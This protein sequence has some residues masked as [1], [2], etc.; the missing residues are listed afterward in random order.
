MPAMLTNATFDFIEEVDGYSNPADLVLAF[1]RHIEKFG[2]AYF[3]VGDPRPPPSVNDYLWATTWPEEWLE[4]WTSRNYLHVDPIV[5]QLR[6]HNKPLSWSPKQGA[7]DAEGLRILEEAGEFRM[8]AGYAVPVYSRDGLAV[9]VSMGAEH[10]ELSKTDETCLHMSSIYLHAGL[11]RLRGAALL[12]GP[13]LTKRERD[14]LSWVAK[15]KTDWEISQILKI[16]EQ[17]V[18]EYVQNAL[19]K[20]NATTRA[21][22]VA[23]AI[24]AKLIDP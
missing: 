9:V 21:Q 24:A 22:A 23:I 7:L 5:R 17:T 11:E 3:M 20:L 2:I 13:K 15:G 1:R 12:R 16:A 8:S 4:R 14:C 6:M 18:H 19:I 10:Y